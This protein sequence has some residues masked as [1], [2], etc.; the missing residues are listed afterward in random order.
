MG[1]EFLED[2]QGCH[3]GWNVDLGARF[4]PAVYRIQPLRHFLGAVY[5]AAYFQH[6]AAEEDRV[7]QLFRC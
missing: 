7:H 1:Q 2:T 6:A 4:H 3:L 5:Y